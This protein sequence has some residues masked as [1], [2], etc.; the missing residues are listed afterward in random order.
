MFGYFHSAFLFLAM[1]HGMWDLN[2]PTRDG[3]GLEVQSLNH[4]TA[5]EVPLISAFFFFLRFVPEV[6][7]SICSRAIKKTNKQFSVVFKKS[8]FYC[9]N[10]K[11]RLV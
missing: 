6:R 7:I 8:I 1:P 4:W 11:V 2:S 3:P 10:F 5:G 9:G